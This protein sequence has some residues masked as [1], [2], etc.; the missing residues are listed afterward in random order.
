MAAIERYRG[1]TKG[2]TITVRDGKGN[3]IDIDQCALKISV[4]AIEEPTTE[5]EASYVLQ[6]DGVII[7]PSTQGEFDIV[8]LDADVDFVGDYFFDVEFTDA[9]SKVATIEKDT[10]TMKQDIS[11]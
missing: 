5:L 7:E 9:N 8:F 11:K 1:D 3:R 6:L 10:W 2:F 4:S